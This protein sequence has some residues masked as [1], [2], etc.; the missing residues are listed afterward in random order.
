MGT[1][2]KEGW[3]ELAVK[4]DKALQSLLSGKSMRAAAAEHDIHPRTL[5]KAALGRGI[6]PR[7]RSKVMTLV[8]KHER[9]HCVDMDLLNWEEIEGLYDGGLSIRQLSDQYTISR[10]TLAKYFDARN[11]RKRTNVEAV[12]AKWD[13]KFKTKELCAD[14]SRLQDRY[15]KGYSVSDIAKMTGLPID[16][17]HRILVE[18]GMSMRTQKEGLKLSRS[19]NAEDRRSFRCEFRKRTRL[20]TPGQ[21]QDVNEDLTARARMMQLGIKHPPDPEPGW[22]LFPVERIGYRFSRRS[23]LSA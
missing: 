15:K 11:I 7:C 14:W 16:R 2:T 13:R 1:L 23:E 8:W 21:I 22:E 12:R 17:V 10:N 20:L 19:V 18:H 4:I 9:E 5:K 6:K 3:A